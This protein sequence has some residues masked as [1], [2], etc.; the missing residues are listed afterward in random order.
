MV[1]AY[2][3]VYHGVTLEEAL[4]QVVARRPVV[5]PNPGFR[6]QLALLEEA[7]ARESTVDAAWA[8]VV[9]DTSKAAVAER[10]LGQAVE[11]VKRYRRIGLP[12]KAIE[13][14]CRMMGVS[15]ADVEAR[16]AS[17]EHK[18]E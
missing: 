4:R 6:A 15:M 10:M 2:L 12:A 9:G 11:V 8:A 14:K 17:G 16:I 5:D 1:L 7:L 18:A 13:H 3:M